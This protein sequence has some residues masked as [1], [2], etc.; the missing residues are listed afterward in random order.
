M[1]I[2]TPC[3]VAMRFVDTNVLVYAVSTADEDAAKFEQAHRLLQERD[4]A[5]SAQVL[6]EFY[7]QATRPA[8]P[9]ALTHTEAVSFA[10]AMR[11][12]RVQEVSL[13]VVENAFALRGRFGLS[14]WDCAILAAARASGCDTVYSEDFSD[15]QDYGG[16]GVVN[17]FK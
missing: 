11:R 17:P 7:V 4:L 2:A 16:I 8:R 9:G 14:Y 3:T 1:L 10:M 13:A 12:F 6:Q 5:L 15:S